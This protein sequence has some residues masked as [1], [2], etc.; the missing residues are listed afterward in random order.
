VHA[1]GTPKDL[2]LLGIAVEPIEGHGE[3]DA[4]TTSAQVLAI[5]RAALSEE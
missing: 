3:F 1:S 2:D 4:K 5:A